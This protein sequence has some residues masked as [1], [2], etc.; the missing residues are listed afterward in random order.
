MTIFCIYMYNKTAFQQDAYR[1]LPTVHVLMNATKCQ[2][3]GEARP[4]PPA[5]L[6]TPPVYLP[7]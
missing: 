7:A 5:G 4:T 1:S 2:S 3:R 6:P